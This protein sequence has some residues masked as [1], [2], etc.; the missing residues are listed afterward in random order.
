MKQPEF[1]EYIQKLRSGASMELKPHD[2]AYF[3]S[4]FA[5]YEENIS[6][7]VSTKD[8]MVT[9]RGDIQ[10]QDSLFF[11]KRAAERAKYCKMSIDELLN[12]PCKEIRK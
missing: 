10:I 6:F 7:F 9:L 4:L 2:C 11:E 8:K 1:D 3:I 12:F 5:R